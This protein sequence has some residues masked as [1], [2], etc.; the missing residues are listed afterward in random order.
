MIGLLA[1]ILTAAA[2]VPAIVLAVQI[3]GLP[4]LLL[5][6]LL[7]LVG[8]SEYYRL[9]RVPVCLQV[10]GFAAGA[11]LLIGVFQGAPGWAVGGAFFLG[12]LLIILVVSFPRLSFEQAGSAVLGVL[13]VS[14]LFSYLL[15]L[16]ALPAGRNYT[17]L[18]FVLTWVSDS[19]AFLVGS[20]WGRRKLAPRL[21]PRKTWEGAAAGVAGSTL[22]L[23]AVHTWFGLSAG[24]AIALGIV[25]GVAAEAGDLAESA[26]KRFAQVKDSGTILPGHGGILD[27]FDALLLV[28][29][30]VYVWFRLW[31]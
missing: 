14:F 22:V 29:P 8:L 31:R 26:L 25:A 12:G 11:F 16:E 10:W 20:R 6:E 21:S 18:A 1:R 23:L 30:V 4:F 28:A 17:L 24:M 19:L 2:G 13:Y 15:R 7:S 27:R 5:V 9:T 3:G